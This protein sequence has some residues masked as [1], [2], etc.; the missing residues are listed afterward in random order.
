MNIYLIRHGE[1]DYNLQHKIQGITD[2]VLNETGIKQA[3]FAKVEFDK[4]DIDL[5][6]CSTLTRA[7]QTADIINEDKQIKTLYS[8]L[9][10]ERNFGTLEGAYKNEDEFKKMMKDDTFLVK[11]METLSMLYD[12]AKKI[13]DK[14]IREYNNKNVCIIT[15]GGFA[16]TLEKYIFEITNNNNSPSHLD[17]CEIRKYI[18]N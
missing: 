4:L 5:I 3:K 16:L 15:H 9:L 13:I 7:K 2:T 8:D 1:T 18:I 10:V 11:D 6:I 17:N 12:R 14:V